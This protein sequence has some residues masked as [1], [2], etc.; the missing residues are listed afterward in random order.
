M[1]TPVDL[2]ARMPLRIV[3]DI[4]GDD[5]RPGDVEPLSLDGVVWGLAMRCP[6]C[7]SES[8]LALNA[9]QPQPRWTVEAGDPRT[10]VGLTLS[11]SVYHLHGCGWHGWVRNGT[12][13]PC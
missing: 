4:H 7:G 6:G 10:G 13:E 9:Q 8:Y 12:W 1:S 5:A 11:P 2:R 3:P